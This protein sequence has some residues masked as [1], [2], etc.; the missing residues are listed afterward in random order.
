M[1]LE[2]KTAQEIEALA[3]L[4]DSVMSNPAT[5]MEFQRTLKKA[6]PNISVPELEVEERIAAIAK[7]HIDKVRELEARDA[8]RNA[9]AAAN[10]LFEALRDDGVVASRKDFNELVKYAAEKGFATIESGL[11]LA[12]SHRAA[13]QTPAEP[14]PMPA[15]MKQ[16]TPK[17]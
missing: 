11:R 9:E 13:E 8:Q 10:A 1:S 2:N 7:P 3:A 15:E 6:N 14:T 17:R 4:A 12:A 5:R 16:R